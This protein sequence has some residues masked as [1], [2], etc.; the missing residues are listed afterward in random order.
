MKGLSNLVRKAN[1]A[2]NAGDV[3][4]RLARSEEVGDGIALV[5]SLDGIPAS[6]EQVREFA[7]FAWS[8]GID[9]GHLW[10]AGMGGQM[11]WAVL[12]VV[13][14]GKTMLLL[15]PGH[16]PREMD[17]GPLVERVCTWFGNGGGHLAQVLASPGDLALRQF[18]GHHG[19][20]EIAELHYLQAIAKSLGP[21][22]LPHGFRLE[23]YSDGVHSLFASAIS[24]SYQDSL[25]CPLMAGLREIED[26][27]AGHRASGEF[28]PRFWFVLLDAS[29]QPCGVLLLTRVPRNDLAELVYL[30]LSP[31][32][33]G[34]GFGDL[35]MRQAFWAVR[36]MELGRL[37]LAVD[38]KNAP[39]L[40]LYYRHGMS[41]AGSKTAMLRDL[42]DGTSAT[43]PASNS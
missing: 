20:R 1:G 36:Q 33:R 6:E 19:F 17:A 14:P 24:V 15:T 22:P 37:T 5:L 40:Q 42:R 9:V 38:S 23:R 13:S 28:D 32:V 2:G 4:Y 21:P 25:D 41:H 18:F 31:A 3:E 11:A 35:L 30:G 29:D 39:A 8:R 34:R 27:M 43:A 12:P 16:L 7:Q 10:L 26:V